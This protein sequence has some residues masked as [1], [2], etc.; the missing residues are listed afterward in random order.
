M[1]RRGL[2]NVTLI[3]RCLPYLR[4]Y[5]G[6]AALVVALFLLNGALVLLA[7]WPFKFLID[8]SLGD[9]P[10]PPWLA[11]WL[12]DEH[13]RVRLLY[14]CAAA[15]VLV[16]LLNQVLL[17]WEKYVSTRLEQR[18]DRDF[19]SR[20]FAHAMEL[21]LAYHDN[22]RSGMLIYLIT[23]QGEALAQ[24]LMSLPVVV[25]SVAMLVGMLVVLWT[26]HWSLALVSFGV[27][28][29][30]FF[31]SRYYATRMRDRIERTRELEGGALTVIHESLAMLRVIVAFGREGLEHRRY[32]DAAQRAMDARLG[33]TVRQTLFSLVV[34]LS[35]GIGRAVAWT[36]GGLLALAGRITVG[37]LTIVLSY[38]DQVYEPLETI[39]YT[40]T[41]WQDQLV[42]LAASF[43]LLDTPPDI[44]EAP[45]PVVRERCAG[46]VEFRDVDFAYAGRADTLRGISF[47][48]RPGQVTAIVGPTGAGKTTLVSLIPRFYDA[49]RGSVLVDGRDVRDLGIEFLRRQVSVVLQDPALFSKTIRDNLRYGRL[50]ASEEEIVAAARAANAHE[51]ISRLPQ[52]YDTVLGERGS[53]LSGGERQR[54]CVARAFLKDAPILI[55][56]EPTSAIDSR[57]ES[58]IL[59]AL[60]R[61]MEGRT[62]F[63]IAHRL[64]TVRR[65]DWILVMDQGRL[66]EQGTHDQLLAADGL[67]RQLNDLQARQAERR[68]AA[69]A[70]KP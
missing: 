40:Y 51:F 2:A 52:G 19:R 45:Q 21:S 36:F 41:G 65:A 20:L 1:T 68:A 25:K 67:Y 12:G 37:D 60:D 70:L 18:L 22:H 33:V 43:R 69:R 6:S 34:R 17:V 7:P 64:S 13:F 47:R 14:V 16:I 11:T 32:V 39:T 29:G 57:T 9:R 55:L 31:A 27:I 63:M 48:A 56:D 24:L 23:N 4:P 66:V 26:M 8:H 53:R 59:D 42:N 54:I 5:R 10:P 38:I 28:P 61:L 49:V 58:V 30:M 46:E 62:T 44:A 35:T 3:R 50:D 15:E